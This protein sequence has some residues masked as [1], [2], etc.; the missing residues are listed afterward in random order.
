MTQSER[1]DPAIIYRTLQEST[2][3]HVW[4]VDEDGRYLFLNRSLEVFL[5]ITSEEAATKRYADLATSDDNRDFMSRVGKVF[6][7]ETLSHEYLSH[8]SGL[9]FLRTMSPVRDASGKVVAVF[10]LSKDI[11]E[12]KR[13]G[14]ENESL[15]RFP[16][17]NPYPV[18]RCDSEGRLVYSNAAAQQLLK[19]LA[20]EDFDHVPDEWE[21]IVAKA[22]RSGI[23]KGFEVRILKK[24]FEIQVMPVA[25]TDYANIYGQDVTERKKREDYLRTDAGEAQEEARGSN[26]R[27]QRVLENAPIG[28]VVT[29]EKGN[30]I[31]VNDEECRV[32]RASKEELLG[33]NFFHLLDKRV[34]PFFKK[35][36]LGEKTEYIGPYHTTLRGFDKEARMIFTPL[37]DSK[38]KISGV[39]FLD[40]D[41]TEKKELESKLQRSEER[42]KMILD[43][44]PVGFIMADAKG[45]YLEVNEAECRISDA[46]KEDIMKLNYLKL[47]D[48]RAVNLF[49]RALR[50]EIVE[51]VGPYKTTVTGK[52][53]WRRKVFVPIMNERAKVQN[54]VIMIEDITDMKELENRLR[55]NEERFRLIFNNAPVGFIM[56]DAEGRYIEVNDTQCQMTK[57]P[58]EELLKLNCFKLPDKRAIPMFER[59][60]RGETVEDTGPYLTAISKME[61]W[62]RRIY[63][64]IKKEDGSVKNVVVLI[65][66]ISEKHRLEEQ[67]LE[68]QRL[69]TIGQIALMVGHDLRNPLQAIMNYVYLLQKEAQSFPDEFMRLSKKLGIE[70]M[71]EIQGQLQYM[72]KIVLDLQDYA[73]PLRPKFVETDL[74]EL[75]DNVLSTLKIPDNVHVSKLVPDACSRL[76]IDAGLMKRAFINLLTNAVQAMPKGGRLTIAVT[77]TARDV[78]ISVEDTGVGIPED[79]L[80]RLFTPL[81]TTK[82]KGQGLG[83]SVCKRIVEAHDGEITVESEV[84]K[85]SVFKVKIPLELVKKNE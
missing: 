5:G 2:T 47:R 62:R 6:E 70:P 39:I 45:N 83:L 8:R 79:N 4:A 18:L 35:A 13:I 29:D 52:D 71:A 34:I 44:A 38:G 36:L 76:M 22:I 73:R 26:E 9:W 57:T 66:D 60:F 48:K 77:M 55:Q 46:S 50:G 11:T 64:P 25:G 68:Q 20:I 67:V 23:L 59:A 12:F 14:K 7:G 15:A 51:D 85:G 32:T 78:E 42:L 28:I 74:P 65:E 3:D 30:F 1:I 69:A 27:F 41:V 61:T 19:A 17:E 33:L 21:G 10:I 37:R 43:N 84:E 75:I 56:T 54:V 58:R 80:L 24:T 40:E 63:V 72:E 16:S 53:T 49:K 81:F 82:A 31:E